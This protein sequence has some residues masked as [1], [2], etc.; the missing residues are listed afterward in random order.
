M[1]LIKANKKTHTLSGGYLTDNNKQKI[2]IVNI[3]MVGHQN[4]VFGECME[5]VSRNLLAVEGIL[6]IYF[7]SSASG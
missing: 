2:E 3:S 6:R 5:E 7:A 4:T 1:V